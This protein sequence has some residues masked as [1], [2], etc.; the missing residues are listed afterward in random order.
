[1]IVDHYLH[2]FVQVIVDHYPHHFLHPLLHHLPD[3]LPDLN[4]DH[5]LH[6]KHVYLKI[7]L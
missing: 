2:H 4:V 3:H 7:D 6:F 1:M 5:F